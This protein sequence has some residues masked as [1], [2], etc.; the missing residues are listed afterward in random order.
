[1]HAH[2]RAHPNLISLTTCSLGFSPKGQEGAPNM[3]S[4]LP[5]EIKLVNPIVD[6]ISYLQR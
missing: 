4:G 6:G 2:H 5:S 1:M 3:E